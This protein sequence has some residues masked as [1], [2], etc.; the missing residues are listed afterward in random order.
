MPDSYTL[1]ELRELSDKRIAKAEADLESAKRKAEV[2]IQRLTKKLED[3]KFAEEMKF[4]RSAA[5][6]HAVRLRYGR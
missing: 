2:T 1:K 3:V 4:T 5:E 6:Q